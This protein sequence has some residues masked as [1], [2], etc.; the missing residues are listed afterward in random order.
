MVGYT[1]TVTYSEFVVV[2]LVG[3]AGIIAIRVISKAHDEAI[4]PQEDEAGEQTQSTTVCYD[5]LL[6]VHLNEMVKGED[7]SAR[8][9]R[10]LEMILDEVNP[11]LPLVREK[12]GLLPH[13][14]ISKRNEYYW[15]DDVLGVR[16]D[17]DAVYFIINE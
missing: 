6:A 3:A 2:A 12:T 17:S 4:Q 7:T 5:H 9:V 15:F 8:A 16:I 11:P 13:S 14:E 1:I 10:K